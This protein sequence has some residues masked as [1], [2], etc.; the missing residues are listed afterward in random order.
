[1]EEG[2]E[3]EHNRNHMRIR[4]PA[5]QTRI[6]KKQS[7]ENSAGAGNGRFHWGIQA[8]HGK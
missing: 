6:P 4:L 7:P 5:V 1:M 8:G 2:E 3:K